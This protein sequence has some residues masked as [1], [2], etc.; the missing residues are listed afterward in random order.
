MVFKRSLVLSAMTWLSSIDVLLLRQ[1]EGHRGGDR[2]GDGRLDLPE[3]RLLGRA[4]G[5]LQ[6]LGYRCREAARLAFGR[7]LAVDRLV[8]A[9]GIGQLFL[10]LGEQDRRA[11]P[12]RRR[13]FGL[14]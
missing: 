11:A 7:G 12:G 9:G 3:Q 4:W 6:R 1:L 2:R 10:N 8:E 14:G 5:V 13:L